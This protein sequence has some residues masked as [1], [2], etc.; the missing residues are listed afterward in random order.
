MIWIVLELLDVCA[1]VSNGRLD[2]GESGEISHEMPGVVPG[3]YYAIVRTD[4]RDNIRESDNLNN[5]A[6]S[7]GPMEC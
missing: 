3:N 4:L 7:T 2:E 1:R 6:S 5:S